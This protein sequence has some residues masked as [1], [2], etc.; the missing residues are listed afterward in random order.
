[1]VQV[2][3]LLD[4][5]AVHLWTKE[6]DGKPSGVSDPQ[7]SLSRRTEVL[8]A[9]AQ[10]T[11]IVGSYVGLPPKAQALVRSSSHCHLKGA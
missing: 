1:M 8:S 10:D 3:R 4:A 2:C 7:L 9:M 5:C 11:N 6:I